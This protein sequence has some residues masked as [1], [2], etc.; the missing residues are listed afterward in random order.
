MKKESG[1]SLIDFIIGIADIIVNQNGKPESPYDVNFTNHYVTLHNFE[2]NCR[3]MTKDFKINQIVQDK[4]TKTIDVE[5]NSSV[6]HENL[7]T[8]K[9]YCDSN[10]IDYDISKGKLKSIKITKNTKGVLEEREWKK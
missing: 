9:N 1:L 4:K 5:L 3:N 7:E 2:E 10:N 8:I 6:K